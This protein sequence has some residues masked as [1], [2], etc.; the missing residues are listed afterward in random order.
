M[1]EKI[2]FCKKSDFF[3]YLSF[4]AQNSKIYKER[5]I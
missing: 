3:T 5:L 4:V 2:A 1:S